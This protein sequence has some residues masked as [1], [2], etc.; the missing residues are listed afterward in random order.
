MFHQKNP[1]YTNDGEVEE[2]LT[3]SNEKEFLRL[4][5][6]CSNPIIVIKNNGSNTINSVE[7]TYGYKNEYQFNYTYN[8]AISSLERDTIVLPSTL[9]PAENNKDFS[10]FI[11]KINGENPNYI[12]DD[13]LWSKGNIPPNLV[14]TVLILD[15]RT[16]AE[17]SVENSYILFGENDQIVYQKTLGSMANNTA[18]IDTLRVKPGCY[19]LEFY[20]MDEFGGD[21]LGFWAN[22]A[23]GSGKLWLKKGNGQIQRVI[24]IDFGS[25]ARYSFTA[26]TVITSI[27]QSETEKALNFEVFPNPNN[28]NFNI[29]FSSDK[30]QNVL[31]QVLDVLG[32]V[33]FEEYSGEVYSKRQT[34]SIAN[35]SSGIYFVRLTGKDF[36]LTKKVMV[37]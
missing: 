17:S 19:K 28:G 27:R 9:I 13:T 1:I 35:N 29:D 31:V 26:G 34:I 37:R 12:Y 20:D 36:V 11:K 3:P 16:N 2:I 23:A 18:Y 21:G 6:V 15:Y 25:V 22:S 8:K 30:K 32:K 5:P 24:P 14:D 10:V 4:N 7:L 33:V